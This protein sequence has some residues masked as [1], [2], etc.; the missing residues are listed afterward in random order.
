MH[1]AP[2]TDC[3]DQ[4]RA[5]VLLHL[6]SLPGE[7]PCGDL[8][9]EAF[10][11]VNFLADAGVSVWQML[12]VG[13]PQAGD[14]P[15]QTSSAHA[16]SARLIGLDPLVNWGWLPADAAAADNDAAKL[17]RLRQAHQGFLG[18][19]SAEERAQLDQFCDSQRFWLDD[20]ALYRAIH[21]EREAPWWQWPKGLRNRDGRSLGQARRRLGK[22]I[23]YIRFEQ[24]VFFRQWDA[25]RAHANERGVRLFGDMPIFV[26]HDS[27]EVWA[28]PGDF[29]LNADGTCRVVAGVPPDYFSA[30]GQRWGNPLYRWDQLEKNGFRFWLD[31]MRTQLRLFD[32]IRIDHFR[33]FEAYWEVPAEEET[34]MN[35]TW[36]KAKGDA[37][38][39]RLRDEFGALP[40][41]AEDLGVI[42]DEVDALRRRYRMP[43]MKVLQFAFEGG[44]AN[45]YLPFHHGRDSVCYTG[46]HDNDTS[47]GWYQA[48]DE[49]LRQHVDDYLGHSQEPMPWPMTRAALA[50]RADLAVVPMQDLMGLDGNHRMNRP[51]VPTGNW[52]WRFQWDQLDAQLAQRIK[53]LIALYGRLQSVD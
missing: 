43:G 46:T 2:A 24:F 12:P 39:M 25:L 50:S 34:A 52:G 3:L 10:N 35:G 6:T 38:F 53:H 26:A 28:R 7:G 17:E 41:I 33:G 19:A 37:L 45:P 18:A 30:T 5:G 44:A 42:T 36:V 31:R 13:P 15:Y 51:G 8:G 27:A 47:L 40:L 11:V 22:A 14:S 32:M 16:G 20:Y 29:D 48:L 23:D 49:G 9:W 4:R 21:E 1:E